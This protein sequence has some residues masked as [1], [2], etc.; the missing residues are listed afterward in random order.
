MGN[1]AI[2]KIK[3]DRRSRP[4]NGR[5]TRCASCARSCRGTRSAR[6]CHRWPSTRNAPWA[7]RPRSTSRR[8]PR[9]IVFRADL[10]GVRE[11][12][13]E[14]RHRQPP[15]DKR[16][17][18]TGERGSLRPVLRLRAQLRDLLAELHASG[19]RGWR[20]SPRIPRER[21]PGDHRG[22]EARGPAQEDRRQEL[23]A[24]PERVGAEVLTARAS[25][26]SAR[27]GPRDARGADANRMSPT[28]LAGLGLR[29]HG[30]PTCQRRSRQTR[31]ARLDGVALA[32]AWQGG[33]AE[34]RT[35]RIVDLLL[36]A[37]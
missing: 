36:G 1:V 7:S 18:G 21:R 29:R 31:P 33:S 30:R 19:W 35:L 32:H 34:E 25:R 16:Q 22:K 28:V 4:P 23:V 27:A 11:S 2:Q 5:G 9:R 6:W 10:P 24:G 37:L 20:E 26:D 13:I 14:V 3:T 17:A 12:D 8:P 15:D